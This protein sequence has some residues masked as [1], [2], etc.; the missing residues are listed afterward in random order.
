MVVLLQ[1]EESE[2]V[3]F[4]SAVDLAR[5]RSRD[6]RQENKRLRGKDD[7]VRGGFEVECK[8]LIS[9]VV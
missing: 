2:T 3:P 9:D 7:S 8:N 1:I 4:F 6:K 5:K